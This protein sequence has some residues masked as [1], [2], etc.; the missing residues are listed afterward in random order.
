LPKPRYII[1]AMTAGE[2]ML[3]EFDQEMAGAR[4]ILERVPDDK[5][6]WKPHAKSMTMGR[7]AQH[8][9]E[10]PGLAF[11]V[12]SEDSLDVAPPGAAPRQAPAPLSKAQMIEVFDKG[13]A[14]AR[15]AIAKA[16]DEQLRQP[17][18]LLKG[19][20]ALFTL[21]RAALLRTMALNHMI[22]HRAQLGV[23]LRLNDIPLPGLYGPSADES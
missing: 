16:T 3:P 21:P 13:V 15:E 14:A 5:L 7:L 23:Y 19:G 1:Q 8:I 6:S 9:S 20:Q 18:S 10:I 2:M 17:W 11:K 12:L 4:K 22:H